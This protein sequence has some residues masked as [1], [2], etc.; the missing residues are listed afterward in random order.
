VVKAMH[1]EDMPTEVT[2]SSA[3]SL[4]KEV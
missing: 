3:E 4:L 2:A 1:V